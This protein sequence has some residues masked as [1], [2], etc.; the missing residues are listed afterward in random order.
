MSRIRLQP[1]AS[2]NKDFWQS[3][4][5]TYQIHRV[6]WSLFADDPQRKRDFLYRYEKSENL[7]TFYCVA[8]RIPEDMNGVWNIES[9]H[10]EPILHV[11]QRLSFSL[12]A[13]PIRTKRDDDKKQHRHDVVMN[14]KNQLKQEGIPRGKW[15]SEAEI[16][17]KHGFE[18]LARKGEQYGFRVSEQEVRADGYHQERFYKARGKHIVNISTIDFTGLLTVTDPER[19]KD[20]LYGGIGPAKGFGCGLL[21]VR[22][23]SI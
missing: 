8:E 23:P 16:V 20:A 15:Q 3:L 10:Y 13:N 11:D 17:Q 7:P 21:M 6:L 19:F 14:A 22:R 9:K 1:D 5:D 2:E 4:G 18:W 12:C